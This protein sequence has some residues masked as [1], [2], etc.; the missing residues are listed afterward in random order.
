MR[1]WI[2]QRSNSIQVVAVS[3]PLNLSFRSESGGKAFNPDKRKSFPTLQVSINGIGLSELL[4]V[5]NAN[6][7]SQVK[8]ES[9][10]E[11]G[12]SLTLFLSFHGSFPSKSLLGRCYSSGFNFELMSHSSTSYRSHLGVLIDRG[13]WKRKGTAYSQFPA[14]TS[15]LR[16][17]SIYYRT[18]GR[19]VYRSW[20]L[21]S[22]SSSRIDAGPSH[23][24]T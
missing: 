20:R 13:G 6:R 14:H 21:R 4:T 17:I 9:L 23:P 5:V 1:I 15:S 12:T 3:D 19:G 22:A 16:R 7:E 24:R 2:Y 10:S 11:L 18:A 8:R